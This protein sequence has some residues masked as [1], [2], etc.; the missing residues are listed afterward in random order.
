M[1]RNTSFLIG[2]ATLL[3]INVAKTE[4][5]LGAT[6]ELRKTS[7]LYYSCTELINRLEGKGTGREY[8]YCLYW[9]DGFRVGVYIADAANHSEAAQRFFF[10]C[11]SS[12]L[13]NDSF[14]RIFVK[15]VSENP[16]LLDMDHVDA[17]SKIFPRRFPCREE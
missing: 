1:K 3:S 8:E 9:V 2:L 4:D 16:A 12:E 6:T 10:G 7:K 11:L 13:S 14:V 15:G 5:N 17:F